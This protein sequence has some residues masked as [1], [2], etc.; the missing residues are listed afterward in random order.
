MIAE[1]GQTDV[2]QAALRVDY[3]GRSVRKGNQLAKRASTL[4]CDATTND[5]CGGAMASRGGSRKR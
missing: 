4:V 1:L 5:Q 3:E 2:F